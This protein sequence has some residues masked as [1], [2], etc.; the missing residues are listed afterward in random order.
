MGCR[1]CGRTSV[2][3]WPEDTRFCS[4]FCCESFYG[5]ASLRERTLDDFIIDLFAEDYEAAL[6][7]CRAISGAPVYKH[8]MTPERAAHY[9]DKLIDIAWPSSILD[10]AIAASKGEVAPEHPPASDRRS[11]RQSGLSW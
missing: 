4:A 3:M 9:A 8:E 6:R 11:R 2:T 1:Q 7:E 10:R 5:Q